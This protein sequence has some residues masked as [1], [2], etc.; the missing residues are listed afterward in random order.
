MKRVRWS[1]KRQFHNANT[2]M[3]V[4]KAIGKARTDCLPSKVEYSRWDVFLVLD[5]RCRKYYGVGLI[6]PVAAQYDT[7]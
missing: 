6:S 3:V 4:C 1:W 5:A 7:T 2:V